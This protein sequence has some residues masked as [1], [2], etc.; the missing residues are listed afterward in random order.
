MPRFY[1][2]LQQDGNLWKDDIGLE[3]P[4]IEQARIEAVKGA[5]DEARD[6]II[7]GRPLGTDHYEVADDSGDT[8]LIIPLDGVPSS[9]N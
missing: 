6:R 9:S 8:L 7:K 1:F 2:H 5:A 4:S 3:L